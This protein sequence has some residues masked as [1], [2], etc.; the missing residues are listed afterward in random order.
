MVANANS[1]NDQNLKDVST[2]SSLL[3]EIF[4]DCI[5]CKWT[6]HILMQIRSGVNRP[7]ALVKTKPGLTTKILNERLGRM[8]QFSILEKFSYPEI[9][10]RVEYRLTA[11]GQ[12]FSE[13]LDRI[14][15]LQNK[16]MSNLQ[17]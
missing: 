10:P 3:I 16:F 6:L 13:I 11:F 4:E 17:K 5:G 8:V 9:P 12:E 7:G 14:E 15:D 1:P 2:G